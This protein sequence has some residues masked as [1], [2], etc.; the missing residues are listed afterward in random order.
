M[1]PIES[2]V[3]VAPETGKEV[4]GG[5]GKE[6]G[7][8]LQVVAGPGSDDCRQQALLATPV[9]GLTTGPAVESETREDLGAGREGQC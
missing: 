3:T 2:C 5:C 4:R 8:V 9:L 7:T 1:A 6:P